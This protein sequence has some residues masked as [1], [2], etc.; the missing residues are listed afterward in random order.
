MI[1][2]CPILRLDDVTFFFIN[3]GNLYTNKTEFENLPDPIIRKR[4]KYFTFGYVIH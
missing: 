1:A 4:V 3:F 2:Y